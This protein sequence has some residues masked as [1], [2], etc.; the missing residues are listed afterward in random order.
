MDT[1][2]LPR[3][4][5]LSVKLHCKFHLLCTTRVPHRNSALHCMFHQSLLTRTT[6]PSTWS[7]QDLFVQLMDEYRTQK[8]KIS[9][10]K[11]AFYT[12]GHIRYN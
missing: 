11:V 5:L 4:D 3:S 8:R 1:T 10:R 9:I 12:E 6:F 2:L 7:F